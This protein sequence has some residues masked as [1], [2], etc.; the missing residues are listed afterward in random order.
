MIKDE[1]QKY[2]YTTYKWGKLRLGLILYNYLLVRFSESLIIFAYILFIIKY[3]FIYSFYLINDNYI[4]SLVFGNS[5]K[6][7]QQLY[8]NRTLLT[9]YIHNESF[10][11]IITKYILYIIRILPVAVNQLVY[12][13]GIKLDY[14]DTMIYIFNSYNKYVLIFLTVINNV[15]K[16]SKINYK[17]KSNRTI[18]RKKYPKI[19]LIDYLALA[20]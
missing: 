15:L 12:F 10:C 8:K 7:K 18:Y 2:I 4:S 14:E 11:I 1:P 16:F 17:S 5:I 13:I 6:P 20:N 3:L 9:F 19:I